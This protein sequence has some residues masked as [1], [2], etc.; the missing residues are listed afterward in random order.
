LIIGAGAAGLAAARDLSTAGIKVTLLEARERVGGRIHTQHDPRITP[1][2]F[3]AEFVHGKSP[4]LMEII[5]AAG[6]PFCDVATR[7]WYVDNGIPANSH[8]FWNKLNAVMDLMNPAEPDQSLSEFLASLPNDQAT[9]QARDI[10]IGYVEGFHAA[11]INRIGI[12]GLI[13]ANEAEAEVDGDHSFR[14]LAGYDLVIGTLRAQAEARGAEV[15]LDTIVKEIRWNRHEVEV[16]CIAD[17]RLQVFAGSQAVIT[18]PLGV[19]QAKAHQRGAVR[20]VPELPREK[21]AALGTLEMGHAARITLHFRARFWEKLSRPGAGRPEDWSQ[22]G[23]VTSPKLPFPT[24]WTHLPVRAPVLVG[25]TG[26]PG[27]E[28]FAGRSK[29]YVIEQGLFSLER[30]LGVQTDSLRKLLVAGYTHDWTSDPFSRGAYAYLPVNG[31]VAQ[32]TLARPLDDTLFF[33]GEAVSVGHIGTVHGAIGTGRRAA[34][35]VIQALQQ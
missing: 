23:F 26:G 18:L 34:A 27:A 9:T 17:K 7:H 5:E 22:L 21:Q 4:H 16:V 30:I 10:V 12:H 28:A 15:Q 8:D 32:E 6:A 35:E 33:A 19:L 2:E 31:L 11:E 29:E 14:V 13:K 3:G 1:I 25:W 20:F 24:W